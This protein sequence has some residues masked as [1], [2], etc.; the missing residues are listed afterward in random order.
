MVYQRQLTKGMKIFHWITFFIKK[1]YN[2]WFCVLP[3][4]LTNTCPILENYLHVY[5]NKNFYYTITVYGP[6]YS[7]CV[8][9]R[10]LYLSLI[11]NIVS[12][13]AADP[14]C[15]MLCSFT[16]REHN[17]HDWKCVDLYN[18]A[19]VNIH[20]LHIFNWQSLSCKA[21]YKHT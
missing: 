17:L 16:P 3:S 10:K 2:E 18:P 14:P 1:V 20:I 6:E 4:I 7:D 13:I 8:G 19:S 11:H 21:T 15:Y 9:E 5:K 12:D